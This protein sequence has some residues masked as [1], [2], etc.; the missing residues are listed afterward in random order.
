G[1]VIQGSSG[2]I[3]QAS[4]TSLGGDISQTAASI[5]NVSGSSN[6]VAN[7]GLG[8][9]YHITLAN[10]GNDFGGAVSTN[11]ANLNLRDSNA[12]SVALD[13]TGSSTLNA[14]GALQ[15]AGSVGGTLNVTNSGATSLSG[16]LSV[17]G[18][19]TTS[20]NAS[21][22]VNGVAGAVIQ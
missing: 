10:A 9:R 20:A 22:T 1:N 21:V 2:S 8:Q 13:S 3:G 14:A 6:L 7:S 15:L 19:T 17:N 12:L 11:A 5:V 4:I 18:A 16:T